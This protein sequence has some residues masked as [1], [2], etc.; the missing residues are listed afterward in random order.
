MRL[1]WLLIYLLVSGSSLAQQPSHYTIGERELEGEHIYDIHQS[2]AGDYWIATNSG[3]FKFDGYTFE[4]QDCPDIL[5]PSLFDLTE[6]SRGNIFCF[7]LAGQIFKISDGICQP[8][9]TLTDSLLSS[10]ID[11]EIDNQD[12]LMVM[13]AST[14]VID[15][16]RNATV[17]PLTGMPGSTY[18]GT[19]AK[20]TDGSIIGSP[21]MD[22]KMMSWK[23]GALNTI[24]IDQLAKDVFDPHN[25]IDFQGRMLLNSVG[26]ATLLELS[27]DSLLH[28]STNCGSNQD[29]RIR[30][31]HTQ[32]E[33]WLAGGTTGAQRLNAKLQ[34]LDNETIFPN[35]FISAI[36]EDQEMNTLLGTFGNGIIVIPDGSATD[37][38]QLPKNEKVVSIAAEPPQT[39][40]FGTQTGNL[41]RLNNDGVNLFRSGQKRTIENLFYLDEG[42]LLFTNI[43]GVRLDLNSNEEQHALIGAVKDVFPLENGNQLIASNQGG[44]IL[45]YGTNEVKMIPE[46]GLRLHGI[47]KNK[48]T[49]TIY[50][51][52]S[53][54]LILLK[55]GKTEY[56][57]SDGHNF[58]GR[59]VTTDGDLVF[60]ATDA[61]GILVFKNDE[62]VDNWNTQSGLISDRVRQL[63]Y[64][65]QRIFAATDRGIQVISTEGEILKTISRSEGLYA[66]NIRQFEVIGERL[67]V[68]H[69]QGVQS[70]PL[71]VESQIDFKPNL[72]LSG[73]FVNDSA[74][75]N[76]TATFAPDQSKFRF[77][78]RSNTLRYQNEIKY[79]FRLEGVDETWQENEFEQN[80]IEYRSLAPG[81]YTFQSKAIWRGVESRTIQ[82]E[83]SIAAP[84]YQTWWFF[85][86]ITLFIIVS[87]TL[88]YRRRLMS[89]QKRSQQINEL[90]ASKL[91]AIQSQMN[92]HFIFNA[93]NSIQDLVLKGDIDNSYTFITKF[94]NLVRRTLNY[95]DKDLI[96][97][98][99]EITLIELYLSLE[100]LRF[101]TDFTYSINK[102]GID[103]IQI[104][105]MLIQPFIENALV[106]G[107]LHKEG[108]KRIEIDFKLTDILEC[109]ISDNGIGRKKSR[110]IQE[111][112]KREHESF[113][114]TA[115]KKRFE[116]L[117]THLGGTLG[118]EYEDGENGGTTVILRIPVV[119]AF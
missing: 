103:G 30:V 11:I 100:K 84:F 73:L 112:K 68:V 61:S 87:I 32:D 63:E 48:N 3:L 64:I 114:V 116:I 58:I 23:N 27:G 108:E 43:E 49:G 89:Q 31:Y 53:K 17:L 37:L 50:A 15:S 81:K 70:I 94:A 45:N 60:V 55:Q 105:P 99:E 21:S 96:D 62:I 41:Y 14:L 76:T 7:N 92:P 118:F 102:E 12:Q 1:S 113:S 91:T 35:T 109:R 47:G 39:L 56:V 13:S 54:G 67:W 101:K 4:R 52:S 88:V 44:H 9:F 26:N 57:N 83:F 115:I 5:T 86:G 65:N 117:E 46:L 107:L 20:M 75:T 82:T 22:G 74:Y 59:D 10:Q 36:A 19:L 42:A 95:S 18:L 93:L 111:R 71:N 119:R 110:E 24:S 25:V 34:C 69:N 2:S 40:Y 78:L 28:R 98:D 6:D 90:N 104:P 38:T 29:Q 16:N 33:I 8:Y 97:F 72:E 77:E 85:L 66:D 79:L 106:H 80:V 51:C